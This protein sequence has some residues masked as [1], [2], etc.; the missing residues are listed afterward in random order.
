[1]TTERNAT[2]GGRWADTKDV[3]RNGDV[4]DPSAPLNP[5]NQGTAKKSVSTKD[6]QSGGVGRCKGGIRCRVLLLDGND[7]FVVVPASANGQVLFDAVCK[8]I[9]LAE[10][11]YFSLS[12]RDRADIKFWLNNAKKITKQLGSKPYVYAFEVKFYPT[13]PESMHEDF[14]RYLL[15]LQL[16]TDILNERLPCSFVTHALL[17]SY[18]V[19]SDLGDYDTDDHGSGYDYIKNIEFTPKQNEEL[20]E[21]VADLHKTHRGLTPEEAE[22]EYLNNA[23]KLAMYG[24]ELHPAKEVATGDDVM[25]GVCAGGLLVFKDKL[26]IHRFSWPK[27]L[28]IS[29]KRN[30]FYIEVR[31]GEFDHVK[32]K[33]AYKLAN[34]TMAKKLWK[35][36]V[37]HHTFFR[38]K[39]PE[40]DSRAMFPLFGSKFRYSGR[41]QY[42]SRNV[43]KDEK[44]P[45]ARVDRSASRRFGPTKPFDANA[46]TFSTERKE[47]VIMSPEYVSNT[48]NLRNLTKQR[49]TPL[50]TGE[51]DHNLT[52]LDDGQVSFSRNPGSPNYS[53]AGWSKDRTP[54]GY[55]SQQGTPW[56][57]QG[58][59]LCD[60]AGKPVRRNHTGPIYIK[61]GKPIAP[62]E[63]ELCDLYGN[64]IPP[65]YDG[66]VFDRAGNLV[67]ESPNELYTRY[68]N[69]IVRPGHRGPVFGEYGR[70]QLH[71]L[72]DSEHRPVAPGH[73][74]PVF[75]KFG[76]PLVPVEIVY[77]KNMKPAGY[78][79]SGYQLCDEYGYPVGP[80]HEGQVFIRYGMPLARGMHELC[81][82]QGF[83]ISRDHEG[84]VY[85]RW[86][87]LIAPGT[88]N[89][90]DEFG[91]P[92]NMASHSGLVYGRYGVPLSVEIF[93]KD[94]RPIRPG[95]RGQ[96]YNIH[97]QVIVPL[98]VYEDGT[99]GD[100]TIRRSGPPTLQKP[101]ERVSRLS[102][103]TEGEEGLPP[104]QDPRNPYS[105]TTT[106]RTTTRTYRGPDGTMVTEHKTERDGVVETRIQKK[107]TIVT[108][109]DGATD[110]I[111]FD[112]LLSTAIAGVT[113]LNPDYAVEKIE[114]HTERQ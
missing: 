17:A 76:Y 59:Q 107:T 47:E 89:L 105:V 4:D 70:P 80:S 9:N 27:I 113:E 102:G 37:E 35:I 71:E 103:L 78:D 46:P 13:E 6:D 92:I 48:I 97:R 20:F 34:Y 98:E 40:P 96:V 21:K 1:M 42:Q 73:D 31:P 32:S 7:C 44:R 24:I 104:Y 114:I 26:R 54:G 94:G 5:G 23:K 11:D 110:E 43:P 75:D 30:V 38:L 29:Y 36:A 64:Q 112:K 57:H 83:P 82:I 3:E 74:G 51:D 68:G 10:K 25:I 2:A 50:A 58:F 91:L 62:N 109:V 101:S 60:Q 39:E 84:P 18:A 49:N 87:N 22:L 85:D 67:A 65:S 41:T 111:D 86:G 106:T 90:Y 12:Y 79:K 63:Q 72:Y 28:K 53:T 69:P 45:T 77:G 100:S 56:E 33:L 55:G 19:Q 8:H 66:H 99:Y 16:R 88:E 108:Q 61:F 95:Y 81:D 93:D 15:F 52:G 14:T